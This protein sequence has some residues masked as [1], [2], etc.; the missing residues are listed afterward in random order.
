MHGFKGD[1]GVSG[2]AH[3]GR[4][5]LPAWAA[6]QVGLGHKLRT[7]GS[8]VLSW[9]GAIQ[10]AGPSLVHPNGPGD[11]DW[12]S[13]HPSPDLQEEQGRLGPS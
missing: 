8:P 7:W 11:R 2:G 10:G 6:A 4:R 3:G 12:S 5:I 9:P 1:M 13:M